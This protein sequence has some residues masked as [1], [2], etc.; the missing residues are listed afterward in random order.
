MHGQKLA[1]GM[2]AAFIFMGCICV[3][4]IGAALR[5][6][7]TGAIPPGG[8]ALETMLFGAPIALPAMA[9]LQTLGRRVFL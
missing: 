7:A 2:Q 1:K 8:S 5:H 9:V 3:F 4:L 6:Y